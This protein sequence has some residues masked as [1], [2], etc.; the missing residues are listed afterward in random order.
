MNMEFEQTKEVE[1]IGVSQKIHKNGDDLQRFKALEASI[2]NK[3]AILACL[4]VL[5]G[6]PRSGELLV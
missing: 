2:K 5:Q 3:N 4:R 6:T 1:K